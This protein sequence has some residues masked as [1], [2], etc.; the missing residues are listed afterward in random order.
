MTTRLCDLL[1]IEWPIIQAPMAGSQ[2]NE[3]ALAVAAAGALGSRP[4]ATLDAVSLEAQLPGL[5]D[6]CGPINLNFFCHSSPRPIPCGNRP[7]ARFWRR[8]TRSGA[9]TP[10]PFPQ[11][12]EGVPSMPIWPDYWRALRRPS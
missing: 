2:D 4:C 3:L 1:A 7:G 5:R 8:N 6:A 9:S 12:R 11:V 10:A